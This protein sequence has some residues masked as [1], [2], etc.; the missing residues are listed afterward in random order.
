MRMGRERERER[1]RGEEWR[2]REWEPPMLLLLL[3]KNLEVAAEAAVVKAV[4]TD[5]GREGTR[6]ESVGRRWTENLE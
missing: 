2:G 1:E 5:L 3:L 6:G 4:A